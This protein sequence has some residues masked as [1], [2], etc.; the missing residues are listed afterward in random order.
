[1]DDF[2][3]CEDTYEYPNLNEEKLEKNSNDPQNELCIDGSV[4]LQKQRDCAFSVYQ[5]LTDY[6]YIHCLPL[7]DNENTLDNIFI[8]LN[9]KE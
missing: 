4:F 9:I 8:L 5:S 1:M 7:L 2:D 3:N 6:C